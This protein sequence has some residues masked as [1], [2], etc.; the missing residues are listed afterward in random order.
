M[1]QDGENKHELLANEDILYEAIE[2]F[3]CILPVSRD[4]K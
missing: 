3:F 1:K 4:I 2:Q